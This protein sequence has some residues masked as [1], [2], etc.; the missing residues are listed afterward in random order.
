M[1]KRS[2][3]YWTDQIERQVLRNGLCSFIEEFGDGYELYISDEMNPYLVGESVVAEWD[4]LYTSQHERDYALHL[5]VKDRDPEN[6]TY[7]AVLYTNV[8]TGE[9]EYV[10]L[11]MDLNLRAALDRFIKVYISLED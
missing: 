8:E 1:Q 2:V 5:Y 7:Y 6:I 9:N 4:R 3:E 11:C 10:E